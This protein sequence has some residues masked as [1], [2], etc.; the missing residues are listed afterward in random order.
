MAEDLL[1]GFAPL[2]LLDKYDV[3][4]RL[5]EK[6]TPFNSTHN[7]GVQIL[8][9]SNFPALAGPLCKVAR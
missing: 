7:A 9:T 3:Y 8:N 2:P 6:V 5:M 4:Q 1:A